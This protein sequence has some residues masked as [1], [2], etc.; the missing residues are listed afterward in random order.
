MSTTCPNCRL[1]LAVTP[2]DLRIGQGYVRCG[3]CQRVF[4]ALVSLSEDA[5]AERGPEAVATATGSVP[6]LDGTPPQPAGPAPIAPGPAEPLP[7]VPDMPD[8]VDVVETVGTG[9]FETIVLEGNGVLQ[10]EEHVES[11]MFD[12]ELQQIADRIEAGQQGGYRDEEQGSDIPEEVV[13]ELT[14]PLD[15]EELEPGERDSGAVAAVGV[16]EQPATG[17]SGDVEPGLVEEPPTPAPAHWGW[18]VAAA[19][20]ALALL[21]QVVHHNR[22][23]LV[24][25]AWAAPVVRPLYAAL[26]SPLEPEWKLAD[27]AVRQLGGEAPAFARDRIVVRASVQNVGGNP[28][29]PPVLR[30]TLQ[31]RFGNALAV[32]DVRPQDYLRSPPP[33]RLAPDQ[34][35]DAELVLDDPGS[36]A[37]GFELDACLPGSD[38][39]L[40]CAGA[41]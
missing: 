28:Q 33:A 26:G 38:G 36:K 7:A 4:N 15:P 18:K 5:G 16:G 6:A 23:S 13:L 9:T 21:G 19:A 35:L 10:T 12:R 2:T 27:Y 11:S 37:A 8:D 29:P 20:L 24:S 41:R 3:R 34:R 39:R 22:R 30:V 31:D 25:T 1:Q 17:P 40:H 14:E 32:H